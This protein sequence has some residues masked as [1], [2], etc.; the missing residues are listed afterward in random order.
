MAGLRST[1]GKVQGHWEVVAESGQ[2]TQAEGRGCKKVE[3]R[4]SRRY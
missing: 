3:V 2:R 1:A 4:L